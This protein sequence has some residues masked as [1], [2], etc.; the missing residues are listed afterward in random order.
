M[1]ETVPARL[2]K[3]I[4]KDVKTKVSLNRHLKVEPDSVTG[5]ISN[6]VEKELDK[7]TTK[8]KIKKIMADKHDCLTMLFDINKNSDNDF[9]L[10][11][12]IGGRKWEHITTK[13][14]IS[15]LLVFAK[16]FKM[17]G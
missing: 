7:T 6:A 17:E 9:E 4:H 1:K 12:M 2:K 11:Y 14:T 15:A 8:E 5:Y 10:W 3:S 13:K 16:N